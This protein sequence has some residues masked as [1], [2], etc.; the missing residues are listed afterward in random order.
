MLLLLSILAK[1]HLP[2]KISVVGVK[3]LIMGWCCPLAASGTP[4]HLSSSSLWLSK[5]A[6][7]PRDILCLQSLVA[8]RAMQGGRL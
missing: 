3:K 2:A 4:L 7:E 5:T 1:S 6:V 8:Q